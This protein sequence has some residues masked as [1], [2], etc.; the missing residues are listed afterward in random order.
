MRTYG[1]YLFTR[2]MMDDQMRFGGPAPSSYRFDRQDEP[3]EPPSTTLVLA[4]VVAYVVLVI[5]LV[6]VA[7]ATR[8]G[9]D[10]ST[11]SAAGRHAS[12]C[13]TSISDKWSGCLPGAD[14]RNA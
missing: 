7:F 11:S 13:H 12:P 6:A 9:D 10:G 5:G 2:Q 8:G 14:H 4:S 3:S 1:Y